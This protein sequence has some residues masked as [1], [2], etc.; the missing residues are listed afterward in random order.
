[1]EPKN[2]GGWKMILLFE[3]VIFRVHVSF[4]GGL[5]MY[6]SSHRFGMQGMPFM[7]VMGCLPPIIWGTTKI[8]S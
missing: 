3:G 7:N 5:V 2:K 4:R 1:M 8:G 6:E